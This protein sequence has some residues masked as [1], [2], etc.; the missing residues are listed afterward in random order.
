MGRYHN[1]WLGDFDE[2]YKKH[3]TRMRYH[4][5]GTLRGA[6]ETRGGAVPEL[7]AFA[8][9]DDVFM[10]V[11]AV[12]QPRGG[13]KFT[14]LLTLSINRAMW[15]LMAKYKRKKNAWQTLDAPVDGGE[16]GLVYGDMVEDTSIYA[17][18]E[19]GDDIPGATD[20]LNRLRNHV[21]PDAFRVAEV[22]V[23][24]GLGPKEAADA[25]K[26][27]YVK[28]RRILNKELAPLLAAS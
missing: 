12:W 15:D 3:R 24:Q 13:A 4:V 25:T 10:R 1:H 21:S 26:L 16:R 17:D 19:Y 9:A 22:I 6:Q 2:V 5:R 18:A 28:V 14:T 8:K 7:E 20:L 23:R 27:S 11:Y